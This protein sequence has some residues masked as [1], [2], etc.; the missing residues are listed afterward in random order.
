[1]IDQCGNVSRPVRTIDMYLNT[2]YCNNSML[3]GDV[4]SFIFTLDE[5]IRNVISIELLNV[6][7]KPEDKTYKIH[8]NDIE[9]IRVLGKV[10][11]KGGHDT[12]RIFSILT[13]TESD[14]V[15]DSENNFNVVF[16]SNNRQIKE[17]ETPLASLFVFNVKIASN[18]SG[19]IDTTRD[20]NIDG[21][22]EIG[23]GNDGYGIQ[24]IN[25]FE[26]QIQI[27]YF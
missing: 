5:P 4:T 8:I 20:D 10:G 18:D 15:G 25:A 22:G 17:Y 24:N 14:K 2:A 12:D 19:D 23:N 6:H 3:D 27:K 26:M 11:D 1:M 16:G 13:P 21:D 7:F 9:R